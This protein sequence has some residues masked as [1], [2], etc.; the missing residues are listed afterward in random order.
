MTARFGFGVAIPAP[1]NDIREL[2]GQTEDLGAADF[3]ILTAPAGASAALAPIPALG[4][5]AQ[6]TT[7]GLVAEI[8]VRYVEPFFASKDLARRLAARSGHEREQR[9]QA[10]TAR[11]LATAELTE[12]VF[13]YTAVVRDLWDSWDDYAVVRDKARGVFI[14]ADRVHHI[15]HAGRYFRASGPAILPRPLQD[16]LPTFVHLTDDAHG[17]RLA[18]EVRE[19]LRVRATSAFTGFLSVADGQPCYADV[20]RRI[21]RLGRDPET[22]KI[23]GAAFVHVAPTDEGPCRSSTK[24][25]SRRPP[26]P[27]CG[28]TWAGTSAG[29]CRP[30]TST[31]RCR[32]SSRT[33]R[34]PACTPPTASAANATPA[35]PSPTSRKSRDARTCR[36]A[37]WCSGWPRTR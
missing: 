19:V 23:M 35:R 18:S 27:W 5:L 25:G 8:D 20:K 2:T 34:S 13:E 26:R 12:R 21:A 30:T 4:F 32:R 14:R 24:S 28:T 9:T 3:L 6:H 10:G 29:T 16:R 33:G 11:P 15:D 31:G 17:S 1:D 22:V 7:I 36:C 37:D